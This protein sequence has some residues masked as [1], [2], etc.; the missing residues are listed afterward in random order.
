MIIHY[1]CTRQI[2]VPLV[3]AD[4]PSLTPFMIW[5]A[6]VSQP[7]HTTG[8]IFYLST[9]MLLR[10]GPA[11][12]LMYFIR[13]PRGPPRSFETST[14]RI[15]LMCATRLCLIVAHYRYGTLH[16]IIAHYPYG[17]R[18]L[19][20]TCTLLPEHADI[21]STTPTSNGCAGTSDSPSTRCC[22]TSETAEARQR[23]SAWQRTRRREHVASE[24]NGS[25]FVGMSKVRRPV[26]PGK[27]VVPPAISECPTEKMTCRVIG[28]KRGSSLPCKTRPAAMIGFGNT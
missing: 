25:T 9:A 22:C 20:W 28:R 23:Q 18:S 6:G 26:F 2:L 16:L 27:G 7:S 24:R 15:S 14:L 5:R 8:A 10:T 1:N 17:F 11:Y 4:F 19:H 13:T 21:G 12:K 3:L